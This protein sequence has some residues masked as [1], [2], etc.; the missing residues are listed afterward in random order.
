ME[1]F[2]PLGKAGEGAHGLVFK[3]VD[4]KTHKIVALKK[5]GVNANQPI[6]K[7]TMREICALR[8]LKCEN[9][10][11]LFNIK[12]V[13]SS[14]ILVME[15]LP[16]SLSDV[17]KDLKAGVTISH[18]KTYMKMFLNGVAYMHDCHII[19]RDLKPAN[20]LLSEYGVLKIADFGLARIYKKS[21]LRTY[22]HQVATRWYRAPEL[23]YG[24]RTYTPAVDIWSIGCILAE[25]IIKKPLFPGETDIEQLAIVLG[26]L[27]T[28]NEDIWPGLSTLPDY[29]KISFSHTPPKNWCLVIPD[30]DKVT[31]DLIISILQ[32][33]EVKRPSAHEMLL[34]DFF[35]V[36]PLPA[37]M[38]QMPDITKIK[39]R[40]DKRKT[41]SFDLVFDF[42]DES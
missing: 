38:D 17:M 41:K 27:G 22:S 25:M 16:C 28:P 3:G 6:P 35:F 20:L 18:I 14:V 1:E 31:L 9:I 39:N 24:S 10:V 42:F 23:L 8:V 26:T 12:G 34:H 5:I 15:Y 36:V 40:I 4:K 13:G 21:D 33:N 19:H 30:A 11:E 7:N 37:S 32:Y 2:K 29:N